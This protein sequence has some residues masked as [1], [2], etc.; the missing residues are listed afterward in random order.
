[1]DAPVNTISD[2]HQNAAD[3]TQCQCGDATRCQALVKKIA[4][5]ATTKNVLVWLRI[6]VGGAGVDYCVP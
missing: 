1:M 2:E 6:E 5:S 3:Q 4:A